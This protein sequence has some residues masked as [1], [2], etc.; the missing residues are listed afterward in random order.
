MVIVDLHGM[1]KNE[2][3]NIINSIL[4]MYNFEFSLMLIHGYNNGTV[5]KDMIQYEIHNKRI[6]LKYMY[7]YNKGV[8]FLL[9]NS[10]E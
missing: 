3:K 7:K 5:L 4:L 9:I 10:K 8:T 1:R 6:T 2:A